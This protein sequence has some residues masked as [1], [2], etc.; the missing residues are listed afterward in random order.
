MSSPGPPMT[1][2]T[3]TAVILNWRTPDHT[4]QAVAALR[5]DGVPPER[6]VIVDNAS[7][8]DSIAQ[9]RG[10]AP[11]SIVL[12]MD[13]NVGFARANNAGARRLPTSGAYLL[14]NSDA[15]VHGAGSVSRLLAALRDPAA[16]IAV[17]RLLNPDLTLQPSVAPLSTPLPELVRASGL[18][19]W[20]PNRLQP[21]L[22]THWDHLTSRRIQAAVGPVLLVRAA[23]W[24]QLGGFD[25]RLFMYA[26]DLDLFRRS[27]QLGWRARFVAESEFVHLGGASAN[28]R[29]SPAARA[30]RVAR[31]E[32]QTIVTHL[33]PLRARLTLLLMASGVGLRGVVF[34][35]LGRGPVARTYF[36]WLRGYATG[37]R[38]RRELDVHDSGATRSR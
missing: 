28:Q 21:S 11:G 37:L 25:E 33:T 16:G 19:R 6:I 2:K 17:P 35:L 31:A 22:S 34:A 38:R 9:I 4:L 7:G 18:S 20:V 23:A 14:L 30:E 29:W 13:E 8:D 3:L 36:A 26:E 24:E 5:D 10:G 27:D 32:A 1:L 12:A 15:F